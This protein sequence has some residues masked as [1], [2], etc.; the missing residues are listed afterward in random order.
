MKHTLS[1]P[2]DLGGDDKIRSRPNAIF[3]SFLNRA[4]HDA[5]GSSV[6]IGL[7]IVE[8]LEKFVSEWSTAIDS[9]Y[10]DAV[11]ECH[12]HDVICLVLVELVCEGNPSSV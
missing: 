3:Q 11:E 5:L 1:S 4:T 10:V 8:E 6:S 12:L 9:P 2:E 7:R